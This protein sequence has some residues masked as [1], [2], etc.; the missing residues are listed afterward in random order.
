MAGRSHGPGGADQP[1]GAHA[2][3]RGLA[4]RADRSQ[5]RPCRAACPDAR[6][7]QPGRAGGGH[8]ALCAAGTAATMAAVS[9]AVALGPDRGAGRCPDAGLAL[10]RRSGCGGPLSL[11]HRVERGGRPSGAGRRPRLAGPELVGPSPELAG[12]AC[13]GLGRA[14]R[15]LPGRP[16]LRHGRP[17]AAVGQPGADSQ[18]AGARTAGPGRGRGQQP[19]HPGGLAAQP[20]RPAGPAAAGADSDGL[21]AGRGWTGAPLLLEPGLVPQLR[22]RQRLQGGGGWGRVRFLRRAAG[23]RRLYAPDAGTGTRRAVRGPPAP[24]LGRGDALRDAGQRDRV[25]RMAP[26]W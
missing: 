6:L 23:R 11:R 5:A 19:R 16:A 20:R 25:R 9:R 4:R 17:G 21:H 10:R 13:P 18:R 12:A 2:R 3:H 22:L 15:A 7:R 24:R 1:A 26:S 8:A 14:R